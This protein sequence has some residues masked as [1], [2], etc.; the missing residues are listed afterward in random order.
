MAEIERDIGLDRSC[1][2]A[3]AALS[4]C[5][6]QLKGAVGIG[7]SKALKFIKSCRKN[8]Q[9]PIETIRNWIS[10]KKD[11]KESLKDKNT[12]KV[13]EQCR[14]SLK[15]EE[16]ENLVNEF[17]ECGVEPDKALADCVWS[18]P[19][20]DD[21]C[22]CMRQVLTWSDKQSNEHIRPLLVKYLLYENV[23]CLTLVM[24]S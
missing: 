15:L 20:M 7:V 21:F 1:L 9:D 11:P 16:F 10:A 2:I 19:K 24:N 6:Y 18:C 22:Q 5:D 13:M 4:G 3:L 12:I 8:K 23:S 14:N 17:L